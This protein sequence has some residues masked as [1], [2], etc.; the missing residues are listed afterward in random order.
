MNRRAFETLT[1]HQQRILRSA[2]RDAVQPRLAEVDR[3][4]T[5]A[6]QS[7]CARGLAHLVTASPAQIAALRAAVKSV[8]A[9]LERNSRT[10]QMISEIR[11]LDDGSPTEPL[12]CPGPTARAAAQLEGAW[13]SAVTSRELRAAG[14]SPA[15]A[16]TFEGSGTL[17]LRDGR[18]VFRGE[19]T[20]V[21]GSYVVSGDEIRL[22]IRTCTANPCSSGAATDYR[23]NVYRDTLSF[24]R[25]PGPLWPRLVAKPSRRVG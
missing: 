6:L 11:K 4:E 8:Y 19:H 21:T 20:T 23:W 12:R 1:P 24:I 9:E 2:G 7:I 10:R 3:I 13:E 15:E 14:A 25:Q 22:T 16:E 18:W 5:E 17:E